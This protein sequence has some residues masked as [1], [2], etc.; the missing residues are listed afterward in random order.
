VPIKGARVKR[1]GR[2]RD[3]ERLILNHGFA[4]GAPNRMPSPGFY[5]YQRAG[6]VIQIMPKRQINITRPDRQAEKISARH[7]VTL[8]SA[9]D[10]IVMEIEEAEEN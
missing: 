6:F 3:I 1:S 8:D 5:F 2:F 10:V 4:H 9:L 7:L